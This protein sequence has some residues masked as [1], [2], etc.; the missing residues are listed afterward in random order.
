M[1]KSAAYIRRKAAPSKTKV[2]RRRPDLI[3][4]LSKRRK[5]LAKTQG[6]RWVH[7]CRWKEK[8]KWLPHASVCVILKMEKAEPVLGWWAR[9]VV[10]VSVN[11][12]LCWCKDAACSRPAAPGGK[13]RPRRRRPQRPTQ[14]VGPRRCPP[15]GW[16]RRPR[17]PLPRANAKTRPR[18][19]QRRTVGREK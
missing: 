7:A 19:P 4:D 17:A 10:G 2:T 18:H 13:L 8:K 3:L 1:R 9:A 5:I 12:G 14:G 16:L 11:C 15:L 6:A